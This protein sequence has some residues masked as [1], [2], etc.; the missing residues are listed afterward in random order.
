M[1]GGDMLFYLGH[2]LGLRLGLNGGVA[3]FHD[4]I[5]S[6]GHDY[7]LLVITKHIAIDRLSSAIL[8][9]L[10]QKYRYW[11]KLEMSW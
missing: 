7:R 2:Y 4:T 5:E 1:G 11:I 3:S 8:G 10:P 6:L 9:D